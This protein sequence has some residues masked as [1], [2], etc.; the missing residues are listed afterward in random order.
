[1]SYCKNCGTEVNGNFCSN[2]GK[3][4]EEQTQAI[5]ENTAQA[6]PDNVIEAVT[7][8][9][10]ASCGNLGGRRKIAF[11]NRCN[12]TFCDNISIFSMA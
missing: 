11:A 8:G 3:P 5:K 4:T 12:N 9:S 7:R 1:M 2:C 10:V 6:I